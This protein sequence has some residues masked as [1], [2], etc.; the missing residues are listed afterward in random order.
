MLG[1]HCL[2]RRDGSP[3]QFSPVSSGESSVGVDSRQFID[4]IAEPEVNYFISWDIRKIMAIRL[5]FISFFYHSDQGC[6]LYSLDCVLC[7]CRMFIH[8]FI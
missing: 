2:Q 7:Q 1:V 5:R 6:N 8:S 4:D 3:E